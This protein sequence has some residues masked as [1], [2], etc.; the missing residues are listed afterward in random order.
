MKYISPK[1]GP[2]VIGPYTPGVI[3]DLS[4]GKLLFVSGQLPIDPK[5]NE[6]IQDDFRAATRLTLENIARILHNAG[7]T[8]ENVIRVDVF[9]RDMEG[10]S[11]MNEEY[12][13]FFTG[14]NYPARQTTQSSIPAPIEISCIAQVP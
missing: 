14:P 8:F 11:A 3:V 5:T 10:F 9:L 6:K 2:K 12:A 7:T 4:K 1:D 13:K